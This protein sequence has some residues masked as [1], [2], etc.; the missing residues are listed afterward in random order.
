MS[1]QPEEER[2]LR[3]DAQGAPPPTAADAARSDNPPEPEAEPDLEMARRERQRE[4][5]RQWRTEHLERRRQLNREYM[6]R[7][8]VCQIKEA[9]VRA[10]SRERSH[11]W[12]LDNLG[13]RRMYQ[14][15]WT[16][17]NRDKVRE[18]SERY[19]ARHREEASVRSAAQ[20]DAN[21]ERVRQQ[22]KEWAEKHK[23]RSTE[24]R[25]IRRS[26]PDVYQA[27]LEANA[28]AKRLA[29]RRAKQNLPTKSL[30][31]VTAAERR[32]NDRYA[33]AYFSD[34]N[35]SEHLR[36]ATVLAESLTEHMLANG[37]QMR[38]FA[39]AY[40]ARRDRTRLPSLALET[41]VYARAVDIVLDRMR[42]IDLLTSADVVAAVRSTQAEVRRENRRQQFDHLVRTTV[43]HVQRNSARY[44]VDVEMENRARAQRGKPPELAEVLVVQLAMNEI[45][46]Q[47]P[48]SSLTREDARNAARAAS[49]RVA[50][51][52][53]DKAAGA[54]P[55]HVRQSPTR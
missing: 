35:L 24:L 34:P 36:Q 13:R 16:Q 8:R 41:V 51:T 26:D 43:A 11:Q 19:Y 54:V 3:R 15:Q 37:A 5:N 9:E 38:E 18:Y 10:R 20:R 46:P 30:H 17:E 12:R 4:R 47:V 21:P 28:T 55:E 44:A 49:L 32:A 39:E 33:D 6:R 42:R 45:L 2:S 50:L 7:A 14:R 23:E 40:T 22:H 27:E 29:R 31:Q 52:L 53:Q 25:R 1:D 48:T